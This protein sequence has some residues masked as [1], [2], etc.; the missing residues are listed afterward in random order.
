[1]LSS[2][3]PFGVPLNEPSFDSACCISEMRS[4]VG[5]F[6][7]FCRRDLAL[8]FF[9][10]RRDLLVAEDDLPPVEG[11]DLDALGAVP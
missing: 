4:A 9:D 8:D 10:D 6:C 1:M 7:P 2:H 5:A 11:E 3:F